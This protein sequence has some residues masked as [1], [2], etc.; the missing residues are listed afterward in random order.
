V[1]IH[2]QGTDEYGNSL[3]EE[4]AAKLTIYRHGPFVD[5]CRGPHVENTK[6][7]QPDCIK[8]LR[9][10]GAYWRGDETRPML[11]RIYGTAFQNKKELRQYLDRLEEAKKRDHRLIGKQL[12]LFSFSEE[13]GAGLPLWH[14]KGALIRHLAERFSQEAHLL[15]DYEWV[16]TPHIGRSQLWETSG[17]LDFYR[18]SMYRPMDIEGEDYFIKPMNCPFHIHIYKA[19]LR[20]YRELPIRFAEFGTVYRY[21]RSGVVSG[22]TRVRGFTQDDAH[23]FC[24]PDQ[25]ESEILSALRF[26]LYVLRAFGLN[27]FKAYVATKPEKKFVGTPENWERAQAILKKAVEAENLPY[28]IDEGGGAFYGPKI[29]LKLVDSLDREWQ[30][31]TVQFDFNLPE[32]FGITYIGEDGQPHAPLMVHRALFGSFERFFAM[33]IEHYAGD[34]PLW[35]APVQ[36]TLVPIADRH[37]EFAQQIKSALRDKGIRA[38]VDD[39]NERMQAKI[40]NSE[41]QKIPFCLVLGDKEMEANRLSVRSRKDGSQNSMTVEEFYASLEPALAAGRP[42]RI[43]A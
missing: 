20:S 42:K 34:F 31:S 5:L 26:S 6:A 9:V 18:D 38:N 21:E 43:I 39:S 7:I 17:H 22:F 16:V 35:L 8:L 37:I 23:I 30:L 40:R 29:D 11:Q 36:A 4:Q 15:N 12:G 28:E 3:E 19:A 10:A 41:M 27:D 13:V 14:P 32:R 33:L 24:T 25:L 1:G 2:K